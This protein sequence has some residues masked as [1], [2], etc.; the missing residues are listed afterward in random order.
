MT[1]LNKVLRA[2]FVLPFSA[3]HPKERGNGESVSHDGSISG[4]VF[5]VS[6]VVVLCI[7]LVI[8]SV[9]QNHDNVHTNLFI[10]TM[11]VTACLAI[12]ICIALTVYTSIYPAAVTLSQHWDISGKIMLRFLWLFTLASITESAIYFSYHLTCFTHNY[13]TANIDQRI[14][15]DIVLFIFRVVQT[16]FL[17]RYARYIFASSLGLYYGLLILFLTN[18]SVIVIAYAHDIR[19]FQDFTLNITGNATLPWPCDTNSST[20]NV[21]TAMEGFLD[22]AIFEYS[23]LTILFI[24]EIWPKRSETTNMIRQP[25]CV[26]DNFSIIEH[27][28][29][30]QS[31]ESVYESIQDVNRP[32]A[33]HMVWK[34]INIA[35]AFL[36]VLPGIVLLAMRVYNKDDISIRIASD[37]CNSIETTVMVLSILKCFYLLQTECKSTNKSTSF[38]SK[39]YLIL[40]SLIGSLGYYTMRLIPYIVLVHSGEENVNRMYNY[41]VR[42]LAIYLQ[43]V[44]IYQLKNY[45]KIYNQSSFMSIEYNVLFLSVANLMMWGVDTFLA[46]QYVFSNDAPALF[47]GKRVWVNSYC[48]LFPFAMFYRFK[49]FVAFYGIYDRLRK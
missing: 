44:L 47:Y 2:V 9:G 22:P 49:C 41:I 1:R 46:S 13:E 18:I 29:L 16:G 8:G 37:Y 7:I 6:V 28:G 15:C 33:K 42:I 27:A 5:L 34:C 39:D 24:S 32:T 20:L 25:S 10:I 11:T 31:E 3:G 48:L 14:V 35:A 12:F 26:Y 23:L 4:I 36:L 40:V 19:Y 17:T 38:G 30:L 21:L 45:E 43:T